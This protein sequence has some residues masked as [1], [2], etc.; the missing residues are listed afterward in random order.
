MVRWKQK[1]NTWSIW[2]ESL[3]SF[4]LQTSFASEQTH[5]ML[6]VY[7]SQWVTVALH[8]TFRNIHQ[9]GVLR[10]LFGCS[11]AVAVWNCCHLGASFVYPIRP[12]T[13]LQCHS[14]RS[15]IYR[16]HAYLAATCHLHFGQAD[17]DLLC[18]TA[19]TQ[20]TPKWLRI[21]HK[22]KKLTLEKTIIPLLLLGLE[23]AAFWPWVWHSTPPPP[24]PILVCFHANVQFSRGA[25]F[26]KRMFLIC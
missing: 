12:W 5:C 13:S 8:S 21:S 17:W 7:S 15:H 19:A 26:S 9:S 10:T 24:P 6:V 3:Q 4:V 1:Q 16:V 2:P 20:G 23:P 25:N 18:A 11:M 22:K 14:I